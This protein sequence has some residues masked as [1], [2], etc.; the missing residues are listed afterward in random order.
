MNSPMMIVCEK[1]IW[2]QHKN[3]HGFASHT[4]PAPT[5][6]RKQMSGHAGPKGD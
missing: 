2:A 5:C 4:K 3:W 1:P 6:T